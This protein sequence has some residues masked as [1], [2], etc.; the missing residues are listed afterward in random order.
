MQNAMPETQIQPA[1]SG[2]EQ[3]VRTVVHLARR[4]AIFGRRYRWRE[5]QLLFVPAL[6]LLTGGWWA[7]VSLHP[8]HTSALVGVVLLI[9]L[10]L[11]L[12]VNVLLTWGAPEAD[13]LLFPPVALVMT[14]GLIVTLSLWPDLVWQRLAGQVLGS[15]GL[16]VCV[17]GMP[18]FIRLVSQRGWGKFRR[19]KSAQVTVAFV[20]LACSLLLLIQDIPGLAPLGLVLL[21]ASSAYSCVLLR[22]HSSRTYGPGSTKQWMWPASLI[23]GTGILSLI[24][25]WFGGAGIGLAVLLTLLMQQYAALGRGLWCTICAACAVS[26]LALLASNTSPGFGSPL[27]ERSSLGSLQWPIAGA[28]PALIG[29]AEMFGLLG[30]LVVLACLATFVHR[31]VR[32]AIVQPAT[33]PRLVAVGLSGAVSAAM[34]VAVVTWLRWVPGMPLDAPV[35]SPLGAPLAVHL[36]VSGILLGFSR[37]VGRLPLQSSGVTEEQPVVVSA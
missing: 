24:A 10:L 25:G 3:R 7:P 8:L 29:T 14:L 20:L 16:V 6:L 2:G 31:A 21:A 30:V 26:L 18:S 15:V 34:L 28:T 35:L 32:C 5:L 9:S 23:A 33:W 19:V 37:P 13:Q 22:Q 11:L 1:S 27:S 12:F 4:L 36:V 17:A